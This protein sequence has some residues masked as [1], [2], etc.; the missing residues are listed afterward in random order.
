MSFHAKIL[1]I[2]RN[3]SCLEIL[4]DLMNRHNKHN[5]NISSFSGRIECGEDLK[6][7]IIDIAK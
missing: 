5:R 3:G 7:K 4:L 6:H 2:L 1:K